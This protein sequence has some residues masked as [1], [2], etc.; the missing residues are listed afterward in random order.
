MPDVSVVVPTHNRRQ[1][2][3]RLL[4]ALAVQCDVDFEV[5][6]IDDCSTD[7]TAEVLRREAGSG[8]LALTHDRTATNSG[9]A[10]ARNL[11]W[12][13]ARADLVAFIDDDCVPE[14]GWL[15]GLLGAARQP[16]DGGG[17]ELVQGATLPFPEQAAGRGP[18]ARFVWVDQD[19]GRYETCNIAYSR[20]LLV[21]LGGFDE[22]FGTVGGSPVW[23]EDTD[24]GWRAR[25]AGAR[26]GF[27]PT[28]LAHCEVYRSDYVVYLKELRRRGGLVR[29]VAHHPGL[30]RHY[31][32]G[33]FMQASHPYSVLALIGGLAALTRPGSIVRWGAGAA[34]ATPY[35]WYRT[36]TNPLPCRGRNRVP[37]VVL[38]WVADLADTVG[39]ARASLRHRTFFL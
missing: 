24:L 30:R 13:R 11:G 9:P 12:R 18:F 16:R 36:V 22:S 39:L 37:V 4:D 26:V 32:L 29:N 1:M 27:E 3:I 25:E 6:V 2:L 28:A 23:G 7:D 17:W 10:T 35:V 38:G 15:T 14:P 21:R 5:I 20:E 19:Y 34:L 33:V 31:P 8:R